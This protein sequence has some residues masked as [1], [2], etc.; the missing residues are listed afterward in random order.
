MA[1]VPY[2]AK[3]RLLAQPEDDS[4]PDEGDP[5]E[6]WDEDEDEDGEEDEDEAETKDFIS[7]LK[8]VAAEAAAEEAAVPVQME[9]VLDLRNKDPGDILSELVA[10]A[11]AAAPSSKG[12]KAKAW[13]KPVQHESYIYQATDWITT[14][15]VLLVVETQCRNCGTV[16]QS[17]NGVFLEQKHRMRDESTMKRVDPHSLVSTLPRRLETRSMLIEVC[18]KCAHTFGF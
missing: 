7:F 10:K 8:D 1:D 9:N 18:L 14:S 4:I 2:D 16:H 5:D 15:Y 13:G 6:V 3:I 12:R 11:K 17:A